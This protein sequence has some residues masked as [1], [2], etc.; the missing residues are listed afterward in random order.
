MEVKHDHPKK[1]S[2]DEQKRTNDH[3]RHINNQNANKT[4][5]NDQYDELKTTKTVNKHVKHEYKRMQRINA[6]HKNAAMRCNS[7][8]MHGNAVLRFTA[9]SAVLVVYHLLVHVFVMP[10]I[11][12]SYFLVTAVLVKLAVHCVRLERIGKD[13]YLMDEYLC[14]IKGGDVICKGVVGMVV[15]V[16]YTFYEDYRA[17]F[18]FS[19]YDERSDVE[20]GCFSGGNSYGD[21]LEE[22]SDLYRKGV[23]NGEATSERNI[24]DEVNASNE[25]LNE[26]LNERS[27]ANENPNGRNT[28]KEKNKVK[29]TKQYA[30]QKRK[31]NQKCKTN[32][33]RKNNPHRNTTL[34]KMQ[35]FMQ[36]MNKKMHKIITRQNN[37]T[38]YTA[39]ICNLKDD[40]ID[41]LRFLHLP[42]FTGRLVLFILSYPKM[43]NIIR[44]INIFDGIERAPLIMHVL[45]YVIGSLI[46]CNTGVLLVL[47][48]NAL[49]VLIISAYTGIINTI[50][51]NVALFTVDNAW[52]RHAFNFACVVLFR[53]GFLNFNV[54]CMIDFI[55][56]EIKDEDMNE[57]LMENI[58][59][60]YA[61]MRSI[62]ERIHTTCDEQQSTG[63]DNESV[64][65]RS[66]DQYEQKSSIDNFLTA[67]D[68]LKGNYTIDSIKDNNA[69]APPQ[70]PY[71]TI[72][73]SHKHL[74]VIMPCVR[75]VPLLLL[76][77]TALTVLH[78]T[79]LLTLS[80]ALF[81]IS[82]FLFLN[83]MHKVNVKCFLAF[84][85]FVIAGMRMSTSVCIIYLVLRI[86]KGLLS[87]D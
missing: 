30:N 28:A 5:A 2:A 38:F 59:H 47:S 87:V 52:L 17:L 21:G 78:R 69:D 4:A 77:T 67:I 58:K 8:F 6:L 25:S 53:H 50:V 86:K 16:L 51:Y 43:M 41:A 15:Y 71:S 72:Y 12:L 37:R 70:Q 14:V 55:A 61:L 7:V 23:F 75:Y 81:T 84:A 20:R 18:F 48:I 80:N 76:V 49:N 62:K 42:Y 24:S 35:R 63:T 56:H 29:H 27:T 39:L 22:K 32:E 34:H 60:V 36:S 10:C 31:T 19:G 74:N 1:F 82:T 68:T 54:L 64:S 9:R 11:S 66:N 73:A 3:H 44:R 57:R 26:N 13:R 83:M 40:V 45:S 85:L 33:E 46:T 79:N 65:D